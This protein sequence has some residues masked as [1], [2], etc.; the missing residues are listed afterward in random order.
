LGFRRDVVGPWQVSQ[1]SSG[2]TIPLSPRRH[3]CQSPLERVRDGALAAVGA[4]TLVAGCDAIRVLYRPCDVAAPR[5]PSA[6][7]GRAAR[8]LNRRLVSTACL[9]A[10][11]ARSREQAGGGVLDWSR[12]AVRGDRRGRSLRSGRRRRAHDRVGDEAVARLERLHWRRRRA[13][14]QERA[15]LSVAT[16]MPLWTT[17]GHPAS[18]RRGP[19]LR[20]LCGAGVGLVLAR[21]RSVGREPRACSLPVARGQRLSPADADIIGA[22]RPCTVVVISSVSMPWR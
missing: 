13:F 14:A 7:F 15:S 1:A 16:T 22:R 8:A 4:C 10:G 5:S 12:Q 11:A 18:A 21:A 20:S 19:R 3:P 6:R 9:C 17:C 2:T